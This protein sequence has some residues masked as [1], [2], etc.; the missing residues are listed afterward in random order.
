MK[1]IK[2]FSIIVFAILFGVSCETYDDPEVEYS[3]VFPLSGEWK[4]VMTNSATGATAKVVLYTYN[5][6]DESTTQMW[7]RIGTA[8]SFNANY[9][10]RGKVDINI[11][12]KTFSVTDQPNAFLTNGKTFSISNGNVVLDG[13]TTP[14]GHKA[15]AISFT[16]T[17]EQTPGITYTFTG[18]RRTGWPE[19]E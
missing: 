5:T 17:T 8:T 4:T 11:S 19:D 18:F 2:L 16:L 7:L 13:A 3:S 14:S 12:A 15:D 10:V 9:G 6:S 1:K